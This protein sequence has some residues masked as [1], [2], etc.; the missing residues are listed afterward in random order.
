MGALD[1]AAIAEVSEQSWPVVRDADELHD[2]LLTLVVLPPVEEW[3][4]YFDELARAGRASTVG[5]QWVATERL[6]RVDDVLAILRGWADSIGPFTAAELAERLSLPVSDVEIA[7]AQ[8]EG[9][10]LDPA[11]EFHG[12]G[13]RVLSSAHSGAHSPADAG[14]VAARD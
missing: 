9:E 6:D 4:G 2:A 14:A 10:G 13:S 1:P 12:P 11:R 5:G 3:R 8:L 7:L